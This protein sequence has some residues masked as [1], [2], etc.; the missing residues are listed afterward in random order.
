MMDI[1]EGIDPLDLFVC[2]D[3][4]IHTKATNADLVEFERLAREHENIA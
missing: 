2:R 4:N 3:G 1:C